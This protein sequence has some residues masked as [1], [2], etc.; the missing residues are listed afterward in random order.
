MV[1]KA[2]CCR[3]LHLQTQQVSG[4]ICDGAAGVAVQKWYDAEGID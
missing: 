1:V 2:A 3:E 4:C